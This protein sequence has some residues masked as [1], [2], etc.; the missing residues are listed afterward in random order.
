M[1]VSKPKEEDSTGAH[2]AVSTSGNKSVSKNSEKPKKKI[3]LKA[4]PN[5]LCRTGLRASWKWGLSL[6]RI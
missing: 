3:Y 4:F 6:K 5:C 1:S 2:Q